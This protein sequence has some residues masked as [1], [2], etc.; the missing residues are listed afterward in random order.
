MQA[1]SRNT[2]RRP[3][4]RL[5]EVLTSMDNVYGADSIFMNYFN[6]SLAN[7]REVD[8]M[9]AGPLSVDKVLDIVRNVMRP[10]YTIMV[11]RIAAVLE[12]VYP[13]SRGRISPAFQLYANGV[14]ANVVNELTMAAVS[15]C[16]IF[17]ALSSTRR[18]P[19]DSDEP[20]PPPVNNRAPQAPAP[21]TA[22]RNDFE[23][24]NEPL[25]NMTTDYLLPESAFPL[26][27]TEVPG[28]NAS[29]MLDSVFASTFFAP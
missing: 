12:E 27:G 26:D 19:M 10:A 24:A 20:P 2:R 11:R 3:D 21:L 18:D 15:I 28:Y 4:P 25:S 16:R 7:P 14:M 5:V 1:M 17:P 29:G 9:M 22:P 23:L 6:R 8:W 13:G